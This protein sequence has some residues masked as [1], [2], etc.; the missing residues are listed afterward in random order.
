GADRLGK[1]GSKGKDRL[2]WDIFPEGDEMDFVVATI[3]PACEADECGGVVGGT[4]IVD[5]DRSHDDPCVRLSC[6][7]ADGV[8]E[9]WVVGLKGRGGFR[10]DNEVG[11]LYGWK[12]IQT[13]RHKILQLSTEVVL[14]PVFGIA[15]R[16]VRLEKNGGVVRQQRR[17][18]DPASDLQDK[19]GC[20]RSKEKH[21]APAAIN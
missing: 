19:R 10:P 9:K 21:P 8:P 5:A 16:E 6:Q 20:N 17:R 7:I 13:Q 4:R 11:L 14:G 12:G 18:L 2:K 3:P 1:S 15:D